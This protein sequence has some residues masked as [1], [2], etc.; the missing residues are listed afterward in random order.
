MYRVSLLYLTSSFHETFNFLRDL[1]LLLADIG[2]DMSRLG[3]ERKIYISTDI[4]QRRD[5]VSLNFLRSH[6][7]SHIMARFLSL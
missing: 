3:E 2:Q 6:T 5:C 7:K 1:Y 4:D